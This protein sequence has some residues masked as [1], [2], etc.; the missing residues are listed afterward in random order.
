MKSLFEKITTL[1]I[2]DKLMIGF[3]IILLILLGTILTSVGMVD[4]IGRQTKYVENKAFAQ[5]LFISDLEKS[6]GEIIL[7]HNA[8]VYAGSR[9]QSRGSRK[10]SF[11]YSTKAGGRQGHF[12]GTEGIP[13]VLSKDGRDLYLLE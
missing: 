6:I 4:R 1:K 13:G 10:A 5:T 2:R 3:G 8:D 9:G 11:P 12:P 7:R